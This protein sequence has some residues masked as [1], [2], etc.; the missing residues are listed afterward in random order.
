M[1]VKSGD[2]KQVPLE[3]GLFTWPSAEPQLIG[4][5]CKT[6]GSVFFPKFYVVH[7]PDCEKPDVEEELFSRRG[8]LRSYTTQNYPA[9]PPFKGPDPFVPYS[10]GMVEF[11]EGVQIYGMMTGC[12]FEDLK[13]NMEVEFVI[14]KLYDDEQGNE[15][16]AWKFR[17]I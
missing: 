5:R 14:E 8:V 16:M 1:D 12:K 4:G 11:P 7:H 17:P 15:M 2:K 13:A 6:C 10:I 9:P 3:E